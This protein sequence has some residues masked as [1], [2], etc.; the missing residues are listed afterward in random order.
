MQNSSLQNIILNCSFS[1]SSAGRFIGVENHTSGNSSI[2]NLT[3]IGNYSTT[4]NNCSLIFNVISN[5]VNVTFINCSLSSIYIVSTN[6][7]S[8][9]V[10]SQINSTVFVN[11]TNIQLNG[12]FS[13]NSNSTSSYFG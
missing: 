6:L 4:Q 9:S 1:S 11:N 2:S 7:S 8:H 5:S 12:T 3:A 10:I 13:T